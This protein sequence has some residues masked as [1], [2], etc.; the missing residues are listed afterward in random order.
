M[1]IAKEMVVSFNR[2]RNKAR[3][4]ERVKRESTH[5]SVGD[6]IL[7]R[8]N[9]DSVAVYRP[10]VNDLQLFK[11]GKKGKT[12]VMPKLQF[13]KECLCCHE[14]KER[15][16]MR[17]KGATRMQVCDDCYKPIKAKTKKN[18]TCFT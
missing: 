17:P 16:V 13:L 9:D 4:L 8:F 18:A 12:P 1:C 7:Y 11:P 5:E 3:N 14:M 2:S 15:Q 10:I 6:D